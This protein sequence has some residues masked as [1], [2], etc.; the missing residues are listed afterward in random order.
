LLLEKALEIAPLI[1]KAKELLKEEYE[2]EVVLDKRKKG[3]KIEYLVKWKNYLDNES[4]W[5]LR[6][7]LLYLQRKV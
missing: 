5:E 6:E 2:I 1:K 4:L 7:Y 3:W